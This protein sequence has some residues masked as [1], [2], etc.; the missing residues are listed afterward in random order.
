MVWLLCQKL[1]KKTISHTRTVVRECFKG[2]EAGQWK[3]PKNSIPR[4]TKTP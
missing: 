4:R 3:R 2:D 1:G